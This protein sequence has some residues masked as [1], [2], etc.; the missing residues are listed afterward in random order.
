MVM[1]VVCSVGSN[2]DPNTVLPG[3]D[4]MDTRPGHTPGTGRCSGGSPVHVPD[5]GRADPGEKGDGRGVIRRRGGSCIVV[6]DVG[7]V[8]MHGGRMTCAMRT[9]VARG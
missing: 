1:S 8:V 4:V 3:A 2:P 6:A 7:R 5:G 9:V